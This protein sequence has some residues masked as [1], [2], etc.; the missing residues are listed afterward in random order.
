MA[1]YINKDAYVGDTGKQLKDI[2]NNADNI[3][4]NSTQ[5]TN[6]Q[7]LINTLKSHNFKTAHGIDFDTYGFTDGLIFVYGASNNPTTGNCFVF[8]ISWEGANTAPEGYGCQIAWAYNSNRL[9][10]RAFWE[11]RYTNW[12]LL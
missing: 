4:N 5:I 3:A 7:E 6:L 1:E 8:Q 11:G 9:Y 10:F 2:K 12:K